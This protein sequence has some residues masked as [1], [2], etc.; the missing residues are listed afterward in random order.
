MH[1]TPGTEKATHGAEKATHG[2]EKATHGAEKATHGIEKATHGTEKAT[3]GIEKELLILQNPL[4]FPRFFVTLEEFSAF[5]CIKAIWGI[6]E[7]L[8]YL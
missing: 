6:E 4:F 7:K 2:I 8:G 3:H 5:L 1:P